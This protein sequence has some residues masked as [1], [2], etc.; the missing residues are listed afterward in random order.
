MNEDLTGSAQ[1]FINGAGTVRMVIPE[2]KRAQSFQKGYI[3]GVSA[4]NGRCSVTVPGTGS[5]DVDSGI[6]CG[7]GRVLELLIMD[8]RGN[9]KLCTYTVSE[10]DFIDYVPLQ[11]KSRSIYRENGFDKTVKVKLKV[12]MWKG[13]FG[14]RR[15]Q[16]GL[17][18]LLPHL[19]EQ[20]RKHLHLLKLQ[21]LQRTA[22]LIRRFRSYPVRRRGFLHQTV[23]TELMQASKTESAQWKSLLKF[24][25]QSS[26]CI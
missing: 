12:A 8:S 10:A 2:E 7:T 3:F 5:G 20:N 23:P 22:V 11:I 25:P 14:A 26:G 16:Q 6:D 19:Q 13:N 1:K 9:T 18:I 21:E 17:S 4:E 15:I 24:R